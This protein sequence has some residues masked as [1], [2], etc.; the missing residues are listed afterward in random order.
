MSRDEHI[1]L[2][3][4]K[5]LITLIKG[6][7]MPDNI[8]KVESILPSEFTGVFYFTNSWEDKVFIG[9][10]GNKEYHFPPSSTSPMIIPEHSPLEIMNIRKKFAKDW[11]EQDFFNNSEQ[12]R[13]LKGQE[14]TTEGTAKL[15]SIQQ[16]GTYTLDDLVVGIQK[17]IKPLEVKQ[18]FV[19]QADIVPMEQKLS[20]NEDGELN[21]VAVDKKTSLKER[22]MKGQGLPQS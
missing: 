3:A 21:S 16:A 4:D 9:K 22:A 15:N 6:N 11:A 20:R 10:W 1:M 13:R 8:M 17:C 7:Y 12:Y 2:D 14:T 5:A 19:Q 18:A